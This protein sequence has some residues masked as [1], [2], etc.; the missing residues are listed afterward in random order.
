MVAH[1]KMDLTIHKIGHKRYKVKKI[2]SSGLSK[3]VDKILNFLIK[4][5][6]GSYTQT[7]FYNLGLCLTVDKI[8]ETPSRLTY[9][10]RLLF[11]F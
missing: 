2:V 9:Q 8:H 1:E 3:N 5:Y 7:I 6:Y 4:K 10:Q 11:N